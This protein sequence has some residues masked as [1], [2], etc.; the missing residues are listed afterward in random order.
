MLFGL[1]ENKP[2]KERPENERKPSLKN[3][4]DRRI[5]LILTLVLSVCVIALVIFILLLAR[6][7]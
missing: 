5:F 6:P 3:P 7:V 4:V 1:K 2:L